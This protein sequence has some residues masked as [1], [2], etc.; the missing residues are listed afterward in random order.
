L[1]PLSTEN[2]FFSQGINDVTPMWR[3]LFIRRIAKLLEQYE[4]SNVCVSFS[5]QLQRTADMTMKL[6][7][8]FCILYMS[9]FSCSGCVM[10]NL[11]WAVCETSPIDEVVE[12]FQ[13]KTA[14]S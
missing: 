6:A 13:W 14:R 10:A 3:E 8:H 11:A 5:S 1:R 7:E 12:A 4:R 9:T 2:I